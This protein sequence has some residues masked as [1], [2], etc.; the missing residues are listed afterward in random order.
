MV[1]RWYDFIKFILVTTSTL[2]KSARL[3][4][5]N[6]E[7]S[8]NVFAIVGFCQNFLKKLFKDTCTAFENY[9]K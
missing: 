2:I 5:G 6:M 4:H 1:W 8:C 3:I 7:Q 9:V